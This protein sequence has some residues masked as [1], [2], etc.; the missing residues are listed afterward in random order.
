MT[1]GDGS[2]QNI[3]FG[4]VKTKAALTTAL[5]GLTGVTATINGGG[6]IAIASTTSD[7]VTI[8]GTDNAA[9]GSFPM[10]TSERILQRSLPARAV[11]SAPPCKTTT[12]AC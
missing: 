7:P 2:A 12:T 6:D 11:P 9:S 4:T 1:V 5:A 10:P 3:D 8:S